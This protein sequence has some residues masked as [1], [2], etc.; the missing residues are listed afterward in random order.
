M[1]ALLQLV[2]VWL[3]DFKWDILHE[4]SGEFQ[5]N[6]N[7]LNGRQQPFLVNIHILFTGQLAE[8]FR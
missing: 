4:Q 5:D 3:A 2:L 6:G 8:A 1:I 7:C